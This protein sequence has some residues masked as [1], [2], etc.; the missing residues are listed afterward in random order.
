LFNVEKHH[1]TAL[2]ASIIAP[3]PVEYTMYANLSYFPVNVK[4]TNLEENLVFREF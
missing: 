2:M 1:L 3:K 4:K